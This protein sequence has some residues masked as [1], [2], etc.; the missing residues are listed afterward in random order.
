[1]AS[2][3]PFLDVKRAS[4]ELG[5]ELNLATDRVVR[6]GRYVLGPEVDRFEAEFARFVGARHCVGVANGLDALRLSLLAAGIGAG[7][8]VIVP[9]NTFVATWL[10]VSQTGAV[11][12]AVEPD[13][14]TWNI[15]PD[16]AE[17]AISGRTRAIVPVHLHGQPADLTRISAVASRH[18]LFLLDDAA[19]AHGSR[20][21]GERV[22]HLGDATAWS[23]Y[24]SKNLGALG[25]AG[26]VTT[27]DEALAERVRMLG[28]YGSRVKYETELTGYNSRL[29]ELQAAVLSVKLAVLDQWNDRRRAVADR[30]LQALSGLPCL[31]LPSVA[32]GAEPVWHL[33][34][35]L[36]P[37]RD[38]FRQHL[39]ERGVETLIHYPTPPYRQGAYAAGGWI[40]GTLSLTDRIHTETL[41]LPMGPHLDDA[42]L[43]TVIAAVVSF[44]P[45]PAAAG[46][47]SAAIEPSE[48]R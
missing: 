32:R 4:E 37:E 24:P 28:N 33:F 15:D 43:E 7:D 1:M 20:W 6:S 19:Q 26:A 29:D 11:P 23:F 16:Q 8:E 17:A 44:E 34:S 9:A 41:S 30:Y 36:S 38:R 46:R 39:T 47:L 2:S 27:D 14:A 48:V 10:A 22:G 35:V 13:P 25:D 45:A 42:Q 3:V 12:V 21:M 18:E 5:E 40:G 31:T